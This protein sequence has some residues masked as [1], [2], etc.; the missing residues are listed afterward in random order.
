ML[1]T[2]KEYFKNTFPVS[3]LNEINLWY[4]QPKLSSELFLNLIF[5]N[6]FTHFLIVFLMFINQKVSCYWPD[7]NLSHLRDH[8][9]RHNFLN[10]INPLLRLNRQSISFSSAINK[11]LYG[12]PSWEKSVTSILVSWIIRL[13]LYVKCVFMETQNVVTIELKYFESFYKLH[14]KYR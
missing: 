12:K 4:L 9:F 6:S 10:S 11:L 8:K 13:R 3:F 5:W 1:R 14:L 7:H 2:K